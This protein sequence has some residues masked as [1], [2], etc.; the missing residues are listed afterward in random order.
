VNIQIERQ[1]NHTARVSVELDAARFQSA[2]EQAARK[3][4]NRLNLPGFR[5]GKAPYRIVVNY[6]G[7]GAIV[8]EAIE[9]LGEAIYKEVLPQTGV[10]PY[11]PGALEDVKADT[12]A[13]TFIY[14]IPLQPE[15]DLGAYRDVRA[16]LTVPEVDDAAVD[17]S[18]RLLLEREAVIEDSTRAAALGNRVTLD[19][20]S[21]FVE[22]VEDDEDD[23][24]DD[25][26]HDHDHD[27]DHDDEHG[28]GHDHDNDDDDED[29]DHDHIDPTH[30]EHFIHEHDFV[31]LLNDDYEPMDGFNAQIAG[32]NVGD[33]KT[34][35]LTFAQDDEE[36]E[37]KGRTVKFEV[38][39]KKIENFTLPALTDDF[40]ARVTA[41][42]EKPL[43]LLELR[44]RTRKNLQEANERRAKAEFS[45]N[46]LEKIVQGAAIRYPED[47]VADE[48]DRSMQRFDQQLRQQNRLTLQDYMKV[49]SIDINQLYQQFRPSAVR[50]V[51]RALVLR[52]LLRQEHI[53]V[54]EA[55]IDAAIE[56][57]VTQYDDAQ[58]DSLR[59]LFQSPQ[60]RDSVI[61]DL[62]TTAVMERITAIARGEAPELP[63][64]AT[65]GEKEIVETTAASEETTITTQEQGD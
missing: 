5:K 47:I 45:S 41:D 3:L 17:R 36:D 39:V 19:V 10:D 33:A 15:I 53:T 29:D 27:H 16:E 55:R 54:D 14:S 24:D 63:A 1:E 11:G 56:E 31:T 62:L 22:E 9:L 34:F 20:H 49:A 7:E 4:S 51:E 43:T 18:L 58:R 21:F 65:T 42:E 23:Q 38:T 25:D 8:E 13:P 37:L 60:M 59:S 40:A 46:V 57:M 44:M 30:G 48:I 64:E 50:T 61:D 2:K 32:M 52:E 35:E 28:H 6:V 26:D 12:A